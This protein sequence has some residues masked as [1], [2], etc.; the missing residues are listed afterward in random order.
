LEMLE[1][2]V[3]PATL[4][5]GSSAGEYAT[6]QLA[7]TAAHSN[8]TIKVDPGTYSE[9]V[10]IDDIG[11]S[12]DNL[13]LEGSG[14]NSTF[15]KAPA[16][17]TGHHAI[18]DVSAAQNATID[19]FTIAGPAS[20]ANSGGSLYGIRID[21][22]GSATITHNHITDIEDTPF[23]GVQEGIA[24][25]VGRASE[26]QTGS[27]TISHNTIDNYQKGGIVVSNTGS[28]AEIDHNEVVGAGPTALIA[29]NGIQISSGATAQVSHNDISGNIYTPQTVVSTGILLF[30]P[31]AVTLDHNTLTNN[32]V[33]IYSFG[34]TAP[35]IDHNQITGSTF[36]GIVLDTTTGAQVN[37]NTTD[38]NG[39][40]DN[41]GNPTGDGGIALFNSTNNTVDHNES[42]NN[43]GD[44]IFADSA[45]TGNVFDHNQMAG[46][47]NFDAE[48]LSIGSGTAGT[49]NTWSKNHGKTSNPPGL[50]S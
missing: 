5:V 13:T 45:S 23:N 8:D 10:T 3:V 39:F 2:R 21:G 43:K 14:Q 7:V 46:N 42:S 33:G 18:I 36:N 20:T 1:D 49:G 50:V 17:L 11:H 24:I 47:T 26:G 9:Q 19:A 37:H 48:D 27:A 34:A 30:S 35:D 22:G 38:N 25:D 41:T 12:R 29:Q 32:D 28:S 31:G 15:I 4:H 16:V 44:G 40:G 6:I